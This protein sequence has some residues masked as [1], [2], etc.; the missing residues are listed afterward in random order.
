MLIVQ[1]F[2][3]QINDRKTEE[4]SLREAIETVR[5]SNRLD[6]LVIKDDNLP[7]S[8]STHSLPAAFRHKSGGRERDMPNGY[9]EEEPEIPARLVTL[10]CT[11]CRKKISFLPLA[12][13]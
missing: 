7:P 3:F 12:L 9:G 4:M 10:E 6:L 2:F 13:T 5:R 8:Y 1:V 11:I